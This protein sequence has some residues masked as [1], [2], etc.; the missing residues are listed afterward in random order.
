MA[1]MKAD[2][3]RQIADRAA[4]L[5]VDKFDEFTKSLPCDV[6]PE[7]LLQLQHDLEDDL[8][9]ELAQVKA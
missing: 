2:L 9:R 7:E 6:F 5:A 4:E 3:R 8:Y 1:T